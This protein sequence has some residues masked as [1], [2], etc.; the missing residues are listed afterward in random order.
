MKG[1]IFSATMLVILLVLVLAVP[2]SAGPKLLP[3]CTYKVGSWSY[4]YK[5]STGLWTVTAKSVTWE[6]CDV[7]SID[8]GIYTTDDG[9]PA[10][11]GWYFSENFAVKG[12]KISRLQFGGYSFP[13][14]QPA[15]PCSFAG[16]LQFRSSAGT[17]PDEAKV[18]DPSPPA[19][20]A[21]KCIF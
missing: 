21:T 8:T 10:N 5:S 6:G 9:N 17:V 16:E 12:S 14:P 19:T 15:G 4:T 1:R 18:K 2:A 7:A 20:V 13:N 11:N 3:P